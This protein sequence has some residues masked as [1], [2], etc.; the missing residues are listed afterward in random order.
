MKI[1]LLLISVFLIWGILRTLRSGQ[2]STPKPENPEIKNMCSCKHC[3]L[4]IPEDEAIKKNGNN[5]CSKEHA[6]KDHQ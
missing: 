6:Q 1:V 3:G 4:H 2:D 5:Y